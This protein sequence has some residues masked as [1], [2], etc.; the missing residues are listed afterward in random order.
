MSYKEKLSIIRSTRNR[1]LLLTSVYDFYSPAHLNH[2]FVKLLMHLSFNAFKVASQWLM[3]KIKVKWTKAKLKWAIDLFINLYSLSL[4][5]SLVGHLRKLQKAPTPEPYM[6]NLTRPVSQ[7][8]TL[9]LCRKLH[10]L[11]CTLDGTI[12]P[13]SQTCTL[14]L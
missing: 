7:F 9:L 11:H 10:F 8:V 4:L 1:Y 3:S 5:V 12:I 6:I 14:F 13:I 2:Y